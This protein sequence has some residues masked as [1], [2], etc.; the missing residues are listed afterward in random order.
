MENHQLFN[1]VIPPPTQ[2]LMSKMFD[3]TSDQAKTDE[4]YPAICYLTICRN[5][6]DDVDSLTVDNGG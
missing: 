2:L 5:E 1:G 6:S 4:K 3:K